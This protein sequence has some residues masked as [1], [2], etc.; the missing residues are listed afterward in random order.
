MPV[1]LSRPPSRG[2]ARPQRQS[3]HTN[4]RYRW[5]DAPE[6][7]SDTAMS[8]EAFKKGATPRAAIEADEDECAFGFIRLAPRG[9]PK[10]VRHVHGALKATADTYGAQVLGNKG[11]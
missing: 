3:L 9:R 1:C 5:G 10:G 11:K 8:Y 2:H 4:H 6:S 7:T